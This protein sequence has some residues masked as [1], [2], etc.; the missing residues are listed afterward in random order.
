MSS[1][2]Y[3]NPCPV[4][5][6]RNKYCTCYSVEVPECVEM[7]YIQTEVIESFLVVEILDKF[8]IRRTQTVETDICG[9]FSL[10]MTLFSS[11]FNF[12]SGLSKLT[13]YEFGTNRNVPITFPTT[14]GLFPCLSIRFVKEESSNEVYP[15]DYWIP[16]DYN[17]C[18]CEEFKYNCDE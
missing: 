9:L 2:Y 15:L 1:Y 8:G 13:A 10:D 6:N 11:F 16:T 18:C 12:Y 14:A 3:N 4:F 7:L 17:N 5:T